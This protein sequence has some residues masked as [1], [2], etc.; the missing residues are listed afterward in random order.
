MYGR[1]MRPNFRGP[2]VVVPRKGSLR[3]AQYVDLP[4][5]AVD[6]TFAV[7]PKDKVSALWLY[8]NLEHFDLARLN[9]AT[10]VPSISRDWLCKISFENPGE[11][12]QNDVAKI[13]STVDE[14]IEQT[15]ALI[16]KTQQ[17]RAGVLRDL[18]TRG[19]TE[20][21]RLR[22]PREEASKLYKQT[23]VGWIPKEWDW[24][25]LS[26]VTRQ[27]VDGTHWTPTYVDHGV[28]FL[29]VSDIQSDEV[30]RDRV[31]YVSYVEHRELRKRCAPRLGDIL[32]S[33]NG[34][35]GIAK[36]VD[37]NWEFSIFVS[38]CLIRVKSSLNGPFL[39]SL[40]GTDVIWSQIRKRSKQ[41]TVTNLHLEE[42][43][44]L[45][46]PIPKPQ[47][48]ARI[49][50]RVIAVDERLRI[51]RAETT[52]PRRDGGT[53]HAPAVAVRD[54]VHALPGDGRGWP[55]RR[56]LLRGGGVS[57]RRPPGG[58]PSGRPGARVVRGF[59]G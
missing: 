46:V 25:S 56:R 1:A 40:F 54:A 18:C 45:V 52:D 5:W 20:D 19:V 11:A 44:E 16:V 50:E 59:G 41:G 23:P 12:Q 38:L 13:L 4:F 3:N 7:V 43:R 17:L 47:E 35:V 51:E 2:A 34:T 33:K 28:P 31:K 32:L 14:A 22:R 27:I 49:V 26:E 42:I 30:A 21:G 55:N 6:T 39:A 53:A 15:E 58:P 10:G 24:Q 37:W 9:E 29:R 36:V 48:Q 57:V 8:Y